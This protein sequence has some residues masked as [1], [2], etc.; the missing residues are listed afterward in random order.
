[1]SRFMQ[2]VNLE[3][4]PELQPLPDGTIVVEAESW[5][6]KSSQNGNPM[7]VITC[8]ITAPEEAKKKVGK[9]YLRIPIMESTLF[10]WKQVYK[11]CDILEKAND[12][13]DPDDL[14]G[15]KFGMVLR[16]E[17]Y[18]GTPRNK[19]VRFLPVAAATPELR[20]KWE[21]VEKIEAG[22]AGGAGEGGAGG[23]GPGG[24]AGPFG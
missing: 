17:E 1:M 15:K 12:G 7:A 3:E 10:R 13:F 5:E 11:A 21:D 8:D 20:G 9:Y 4:V 19:E 16:L 24:S 14:L 22:G 23:A 6:E 18:Q 2:N